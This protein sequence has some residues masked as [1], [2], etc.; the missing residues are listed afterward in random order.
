MTN[1][2]R[3]HSP[4]LPQLASDVWSQSRKDTNSSWATSLLLC[5]PRAA[6]KKKVMASHQLARSFNSLPVETLHEIVLYLPR[7][8]LR[9]LLLLQP[10]PLGQVASYVYFSTLSLR[11]GICQSYLS[12]CVQTDD[13]LTLWHQKRSIEILEAIINDANFASRVKR[14]NLSAVGDSSE[15]LGALQCG[16]L[17]C[18]RSPHLKIYSVWLCLS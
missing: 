11:F 6:K 10:H 18:F 9:G 7:H 13:P 12:W 14:L 1:F 5:N 8:S 4:R 2:R 15:L 17:P 3:D 16:L